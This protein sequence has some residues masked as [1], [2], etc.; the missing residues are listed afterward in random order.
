ML[1]QQTEDVANMIGPSALAFSSDIIPEELYMPRMTDHHGDHSNTTV[2]QLEKDYKQASARLRNLLGERQA[3]RE[4]LYHWQSG[5][6]RLAHELE[7]HR[8]HIHSNG[9]APSDGKSKAFTPQQL[10]IGISGD[11]DWEERVVAKFYQRKAEYTRLT[12]RVRPL[13]KDMEIKKARLE[14]QRS[15]Y[16]TQLETSCSTLKRLRS[17]M[18]LD[19]EEDPA[20]DS[21]T[22]ENPDSATNTGSVEITHLANADISDSS[23]N[24]EDDA[25]GTG[26]GEVVVGGKYKCSELRCE[27]YVY[28]FETVE[29]LMRHGRLHEKAEEA[30]EAIKDGTVTSRGSV[31]AAAA[32][33]RSG[34]SNSGMST[35]WR[36]KVLRKKCDIQNPCK[37]CPQQNSIPPSPWQELGC[38][39][40]PLTGMV[41]QC[42]HGLPHLATGSPSDIVRDAGLDYLVKNYPGFVSLS[43][44]FWNSR[45][46]LPPIGGMNTTTDLTDVSCLS[47]EY[48]SAVGL[49]KTAVLN[50]AYLGQAAYNPFALLRVG[51]E[52]MSACNDPSS[53]SLYNHAQFL[54]LTALHYRLALASALPTTST[55]LTDPLTAFLIE[56]DMRFSSRKDVSPSGW[57]A[58]FHSLC[59]FSITK[60][61]L[62]DTPTQHQSKLAAAY[63]ILVSIFSW[64]AKFSAWCP[65]ESSE[66]RDPLIKDWSHG[67]NDAVDS[68]IRVAL[69]ATQSLVYRNEWEKSRI[70]HTRDFLNRLGTRNVEGKFNGFLGC[71]VGEGFA[72]PPPAER[73]MEGDKEIFKLPSAPSRVT[74]PTSSSVSREKSKRR[75]DVAPP[76][77]ESSVFGAENCSMPLPS[78]ATLASSS[79]DGGPRSGESPSNAAHKL[80]RMRELS[81]NQRDH[82][83]AMRKLGACR[84][85]KAKK[86]ACS[87]THSRGGPGPTSPRTQG[88][89]E[90]GYHRCTWGWACSRV[91]PAPTSLTA[92]TVPAGGPLLRNEYMSADSPS[93]KYSP[94]DTLK[95]NYGSRIPSI[96]MKTMLP[97]SS[98]S[99]FLFK[100]VRAGGEA[101]IASA[102]SLKAVLMARMNQAGSLVGNTNFSIC[103]VAS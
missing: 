3:K 86:V 76:G 77:P 88:G 10:V 44:E 79:S 56:F 9:D 8:K 33:S 70:R 13:Q 89:E 92:K 37:A 73:R 26:D 52:A 57:L 99:A 30:E 63:K 42:L 78:F 19:F 7:E 83:A 18:T 27:H 97:P 11:K 34:A 61:I 15:W 36:C 100:F 22:M 69:Q 46:E 38:F 14:K 93:I 59:L 68:Q 21:D 95:W 23:P 96:N 45:K 51:R 6:E 67:S 39:R 40:G 90:A 85:C 54:L 84:E 101:E 41:G 66:L 25:K 53:W 29:A 47:L 102:D 31:D 5:I 2:I 32:T 50:R 20:D 17:I 49:L 58:A 1:D 80:P 82:A 28:G 12:E 16:S 4:F 94:F 62:I 75:G 74:S 24:G 43:D 87:Y 64:S 98:L 60:T 55:P 35:C 65:Q 81:S 72:T 103:I 71:V 91:D 48:S